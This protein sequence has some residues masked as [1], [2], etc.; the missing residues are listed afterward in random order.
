MVNCYKTN[1]MVSQLLCKNHMF[2]LNVEA[3]F[4]DS[5]KVKAVV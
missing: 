3:L 2:S 4:S 1:K 5:E